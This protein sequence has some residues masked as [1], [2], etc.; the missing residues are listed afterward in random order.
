MTV[1]FIDLPE[2]AELHPG[3]SINLITF[4][5]WPVQMLFTGINVREA[6]QLLAVRQAR[7]IGTFYP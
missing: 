7:R 6:R 2:G 1:G 4:W 3:E 5:H